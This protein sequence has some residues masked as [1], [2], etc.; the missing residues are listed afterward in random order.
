MR[1][2]RQP[3]SPTIA[4]QNNCAPASLWT[5]NNHYATYHINYQGKRILG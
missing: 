4:S 3:G 1:A 2:G 5:V